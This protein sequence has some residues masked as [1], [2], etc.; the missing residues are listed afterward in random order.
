VPVNRDR[1]VDRRWVSPS[2]PDLLVLDAPS[3]GEVP[4]Y[5]QDP[6]GA[7]DRSGWAEETSLDVELSH[8][9]APGANILLVETPQ[10]ETEGVHGFPETVRAE[11]L[12]HRSQPRPSPGWSTAIAVRP[13]SA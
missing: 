1:C 7:A 6:F 2:V 9:M 3:R 10:S 4:P 13:T 8:V 5:P 11:E 12:R